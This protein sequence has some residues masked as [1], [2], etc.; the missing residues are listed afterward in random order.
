M[1]QTDNVL[2]KEAKVLRELLEKGN[3]NL[4]TL[5]IFLKKVE[6]TVPNKVLSNQSDELFLKHLNRIYNNK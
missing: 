1:S 2:A 5:R 4:N 3:I 6:E